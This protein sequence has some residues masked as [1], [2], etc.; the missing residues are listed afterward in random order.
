MTKNRTILYALLLLPALITS[1][2][3]GCY[4][5]PQVALELNEEDVKFRVPVGFP[6]PAYDFSLNPVT[7]DGFELGRKLFYDPRLSR[8]NTISCGTCHQQVSA[9]A[10]TSHQVSHGIDGLFGTRNAPGLWNLAWHSTFM[11][12]GGIQHIELQPLGPIANPVEMDEDIN[13]I[14]TKLKNDALYPGMF[15]A[16]FGNDTITTQ[17]ITQAITQ[18]QGLMISDNSKYDQYARGETT[19]TPAELAGLATFRSKCATCHTEPLFS[20]NSY[21]N[22]GLAPEPTI[23]DAGRMHITNDPADSLKFR[24]PSLRNIAVTGPYMHDGRYATL[25]QC[26]NHYTSPMYQSATLDPLLS[27][28]ISLTTQEKSDLLAFLATL[29]DYTFIQ[30]PKFKEQ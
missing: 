2:V 28:G 9:F 24:T 7:V 3:S 25:S 6:A 15:K 17:R 10:N 26:L 8:D 27:S 12:D 1:L 30:D 22:N 18:F 5:D 23:M 11:W 16:A 29:T 14:I 21:H 4:R 13:N 19:L 20:D